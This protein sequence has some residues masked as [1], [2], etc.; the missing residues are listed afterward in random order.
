MLFT[1]MKSAKLQERK[2]ESACLEWHYVYGV[3]RYEDQTEEILYEIEKN[4]Y[5]GNLRY[6]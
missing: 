3:P 5:F 4:F 1:H 2:V 6:K